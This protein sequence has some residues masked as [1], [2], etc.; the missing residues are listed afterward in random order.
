MSPPNTPCTS[1]ASAASA[2]F[3][4]ASGGSTAGT[5]EA[6]WRVRTDGS[7]VENQDAVG[8]QKKLVLSTNLCNSEGNHLETRQCFD[9][10]ILDCKYQRFWWRQYVQK[11]NESCES[12]IQ[13]WLRHHDLPLCFLKKS[14]NPFL[15][16][17]LNV[18]N[19]AQQFPKT[20]RTI[21]RNG[22]T[23]F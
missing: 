15:S 1:T 17:Q 12:R 18:N 20:N 8:D 5:L 22:H 9:F 23:C 2:G 6:S 14:P 7:E 10:R 13:V 16:S 11:W 4:S 21:G 19:P 3:E